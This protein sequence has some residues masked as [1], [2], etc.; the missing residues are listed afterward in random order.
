MTYP[1]SSTLIEILWINQ[2]ELESTMTKL[3]NCDVVIEENATWERGF[4][5]KQQCSFYI[6]KIMYIKEWKRIWYASSKE[7]RNSR[8]SIDVWHMMIY[9][10]CH[11]KRRKGIV[12]KGH[13]MQSER[14]DYVI[15]NKNIYSLNEIGSEWERLTRVYTSSQC[16]I[17]ADCE[18][19]AQNVSLIPSRLSQLANGELV[20]SRDRPT[21]CTRCYATK[22]TWVTVINR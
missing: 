19:L 15:G 10:H 5:S 9:R 4:P 13:L 14:N 18:I 12:M 16:K 22:F 6:I 1:R 21:S 3:D 17:P 2:D 20:R 7:T 11:W 8:Y